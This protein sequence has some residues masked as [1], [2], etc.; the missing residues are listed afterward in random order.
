MA[1]HTRKS[2]H[3]IGGGFA[4]AQR[5]HVFAQLR[6][7]A[8]RQQCRGIVIVKQFAKAHE[9][10]ACKGDGFA[11]RPVDYALVAMI[12][13]RRVEAEDPVSAVAVHGAAV[14]ANH[15]EELSPDRGFIDTGPLA[16][17]GIQMLQRPLLEWLDT[18]VCEYV[19]RAG[20]V[21]KKNTAIA[22]H[23][24]L[25]PVV[26]NPRHGNRG[27]GER[28]GID[29]SR[30]HTRAEAAVALVHGG[31]QYFHGCDFRTLTQQIV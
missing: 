1:L 12:G 3:R 20:P 31:A 13:R 14:F 17:Q 19:H 8:Y 30:T 10:I 28:G 6:I 24:H 26:G 11:I 23:G 27:R 2:D 15:R 7:V 4:F 5:G 9:T 16:R 25:Q 18:P 22:K 21:A 29:L